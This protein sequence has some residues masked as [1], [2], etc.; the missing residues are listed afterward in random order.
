[1][2][3]KIDD[4]SYT[5]K[6]KSMSSL[7]EK[8]E[9]G[10]EQTKHQYEFQEICADLEKDFGKRIWTLPH[11]NKPYITN[12]NLRKAGQIA[13]SRNITTINY[14]IGIMKNL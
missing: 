2:Y 6:P 1:M 9:I 4:E 12:H 13:R 3:H 14:L 7:F 8:F 5:K 10:R 11:Q